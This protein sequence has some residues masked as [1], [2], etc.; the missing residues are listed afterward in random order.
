VP[1]PGALG[2]PCADDLACVDGLCAERADRGPRVC[3]RRCFIDLPSFC[4]GGYECVASLGRGGGEA[5]FAP[6]TGGCAFARGG[7]DSA[8]WAL[9]IVL[10]VAGLRRRT[11]SW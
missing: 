8:P 3:A 7:R 5:C 9:V 2:A 11:G 4:P 1:S 10:L 6:R